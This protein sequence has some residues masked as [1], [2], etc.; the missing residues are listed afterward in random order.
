MEW[1]HQKT[2]DVLARTKS[3]I[4]AL[5]I[6]KLGTGLWKLRDHGRI[7]G[8]SSYKRK[9]KLQE[10]FITYT[11]NKLLSVFNAAETPDKR[12]HVSE[13]SEIRTGH[14]TDTFNKIREHYGSQY[15]VKRGITIDLS[16]NKCFSVILKG[17]PNLDLVAEEDSIRNLWVDTLSQL[18][19]TINVLESDSNYEA[20]LINL[21]RNAD[22][23]GNGRIAYD[24]FVGLSDE[25]HLQMGKDQILSV[26]QIRIF[27]K[28]IFR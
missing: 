27:T 20:Y 11:G 17:R 24:E 18:I 15:N 2:S 25:L 21:F 9:Y 5:N 13:I 8:I 12:L 22:K 6:L 26:F 7:R 10:L 14:G 23:N 1:K 4:E 16:P 28:R 3:M 19:T